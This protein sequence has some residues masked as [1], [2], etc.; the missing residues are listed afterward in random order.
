MAQFVAR[1]LLMGQAKEHEA[2][3]DIES[4]IWSFSYCVCRKL[5]QSILDSQEKLPEIKNQKEEFY[6]LYSMVFSQTEPNMIASMR[7]PPSFTINFVDDDDIKD[8]VET[9]MSAPLITLFQRFPLMIVKSQPPFGQVP[10][11]HDALLL[12]VDEAISSY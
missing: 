5:W 9:F 6:K 12:V 4:F 7:V 2:E 3:H 10:L 1:A 8:I 11:T